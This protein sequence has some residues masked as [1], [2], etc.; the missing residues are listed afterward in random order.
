MVGAGARRWSRHGGVA[1]RPILVR[2]R[3]IGG[4]AGVDRAKGV[5]RGTSAVRWSTGWR[6]VACGIREGLWVIDDQ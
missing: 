4:L 2:A 6:S 5:G 3:A 1:P